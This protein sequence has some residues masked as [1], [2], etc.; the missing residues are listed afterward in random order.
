MPPTR[1]AAELL[2]VLRP[3]LLAPPPP[4]PAQATKQRE[5]RSAERALRAK[6]LTPELAAQVVKIP[7]PARRALMSL[8]TGYCQLTGIAFGTGPKAPVLTRDRLFVLRTVA[9]SMGT[10]PPAAFVA[11][12]RRVA[13]HADR[14]P[15]SPAPQHQPPTQPRAAR[16]PPA[17]TK[18]EQQHDDDF[19]LRAPLGLQ[20]QDDRP[21]DPHRPAGGERPAGHGGG[22]W[23]WDDQRGRA[24]LGTA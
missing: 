3:T 9:D 4:T 23:T 14:A 21:E 19:D 13:E 17:P 24:V 20:H 12:C 11:L 8:W 6:G 10:M 18:Q 22:V 5:R 7:Q 15:P 1:T 16:T 2:E